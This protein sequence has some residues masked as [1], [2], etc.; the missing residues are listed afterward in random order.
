MRELPSGRTVS[1]VRR[2]R[3]EVSEMPPRA[4]SGADGWKKRRPPAASPPRPSVMFTNP[5]YQA[6][7]DP[8]R[9][10]PRFADLVRRIG[11]PKR[12]ST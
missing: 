1:A 9:A 3:L 6:F 12:S 2:A 11:L 4:R 7:F 5:S 10:D 8:L